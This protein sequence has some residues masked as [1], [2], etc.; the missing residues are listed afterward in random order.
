VILSEI[1][2]QTEDSEEITV[3]ERSFVLVKNRRKKYR[4]A[5]NGCIETAP[6]WPVLKCRRMAGLEVS[7]EVGL[8]STIPIP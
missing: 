5:C 4:C 8:A 1:S 3:V 7:T 2:G 6:Y